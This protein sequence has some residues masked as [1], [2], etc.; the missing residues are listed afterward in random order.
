M[1]TAPEKLEASLQEV[2]A[3]FV[4]VAKTKTAFPTRCHQAPRLRATRRTPKASATPAANRW[5]MLLTGS[6]KPGMAYTA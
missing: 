2:I 4:T 3:L 6:A 1:K 5:V